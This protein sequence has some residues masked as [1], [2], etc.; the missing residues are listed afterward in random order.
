MK[1]GRGSPKGARKAATETCCTSGSSPVRYLRMS[2]TLFSRAATS[3]RFSSFRRRAMA[4]NAA[5]L[6]LK[7]LTRLILQS[8]GF[9]SVLL[10]NVGKGCAPVEPYC[11][12]SRHSMYRRISNLQNAE[13]QSSLEAV[14][15]Y[16]RWHCYLVKH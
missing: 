10:T 12:L 8:C 13:V 1:G 14:S 3:E 4:R 6:P 7:L 5:L 9:K 15:S 11:S 16:R 2:V